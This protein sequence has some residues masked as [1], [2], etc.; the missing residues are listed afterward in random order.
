VAAAVADVNALE[1][2]LTPAA[3]TDEFSHD[4]AAAPLVVVDTNLSP[5]ALQVGKHCTTSL[6]RTGQPSKPDAIAHCP[7]LQECALGARGPQAAELS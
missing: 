7:G 5:A 1:K 6:S 2:A 4:V 3:L